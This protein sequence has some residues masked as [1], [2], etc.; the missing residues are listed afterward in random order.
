MHGHLS[1]VELGRARVNPPLLISVV[2]EPTV[3][4]GKCTITAIAAVEAYYDIGRL[5]RQSFFK[6]EGRNISPLWKASQQ[7]PLN[8]SSRT[9][10]TELVV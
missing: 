10:S 2:V 5:A 4:R 6:S 7:A 3:D 8:S 9:D 1:Q